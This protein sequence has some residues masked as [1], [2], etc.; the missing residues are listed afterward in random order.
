MTGSLA[1][2]KAGRPAGIGRPAAAS[3]WRAARRH[4]PGVEVGR[5]S[6]SLELPQVGLGQLDELGSLAGQDG[7]A[8][9]EDEALYLAVRELGR[10]GQLVAGGADVHQGRAVVLERRAQRTL[11]IAS[12]LHPLAVQV[13]GARD[14]KRSPGYP[15]RRQR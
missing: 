12:L 3:A 15:G 5:G 6:F 2:P 14:A 7:P 11:Q 10:Q 4:A 13:A 1:V 8:G 9:L